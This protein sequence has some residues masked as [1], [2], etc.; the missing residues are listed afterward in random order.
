MS[1]FPPAYP[2]NG[3]VSSTLS[4]R[5]FAFDTKTTKI[6]FLSLSLSFSLTICRFSNCE[7]ALVRD[8]TLPVIPSF[9]YAT[10]KGLQDFVKFL[11]EVLLHV[12]PT[13]NDMRV[14]AWYTYLRDPSQLHHGFVRL[15]SSLSHFCTPLPFFCFAITALLPP[16]HFT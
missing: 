15:P 7:L 11:Y 5:F 13:P 14:W 2:R 8:G 16:T 1:P 4:K 6:A 12:R 9:V 10:Q 3:H